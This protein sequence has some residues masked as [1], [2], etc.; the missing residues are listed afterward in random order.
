MGRGTTFGFPE[1]KR[2][3]PDLG[4]FPMG[5]WSTSIAAVAIPLGFP[6][7]DGARHDLGDSRRGNG[8]RPTLGVSGW[9]NWSAPIYAHPR[10]S[11]PIPSTSIRG[12][13]PPTPRALW[14]KARGCA[15]AALPR[16][17]GEVRHN[18]EGVVPGDR[19]G[20]LTRRGYGVV[21]QI[22]WALCPFGRIAA[23]PANLP[24][25]YDSTTLPGLFGC[26]PSTH[27]STSAVQPWALCQNPVGNS[28]PGQGVLL[29]DW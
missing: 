2:R 7:G 1:G 17:S 10:P 8:D 20:A 5:N 12:S 19:T 18:P 13:P 28:R 22:N 14:H 4:R 3:S 27:G 29:V 25:F 11:T 15:S 16:V 23:P 6:E 26:P 9:G 24:G 21:M